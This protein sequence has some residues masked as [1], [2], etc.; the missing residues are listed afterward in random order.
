MAPKSDLM[1]SYV[2]KAQAI[3]YYNT[4][5]L[6]PMIREVAQDAI[7][8][9]Y[10]GELVE[11]MVNKQAENQVEQAVAEALAEE[12]GEEAMVIFKTDAERAFIDQTMFEVMME[13][14]LQ[15]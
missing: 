15:L 14:V 7:S 10:I 12:Q 4:V 5:L 8:D 1:K 6:E 2:L 3:P 13:E 11:E 9:I